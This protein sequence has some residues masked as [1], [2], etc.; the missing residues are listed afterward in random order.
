[1][2]LDSYN[3]TSKL[4]SNSGHKQALKEILWAKIFDLQSAEV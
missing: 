3:T 2:A 4:Y 1:M